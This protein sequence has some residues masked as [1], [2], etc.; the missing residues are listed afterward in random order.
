MAAS[1]AG[2]AAVAAGIASDCALLAAAGAGAT[3]KRSDGAVLC[4]SGV[5]D[6][7]D[8]GMNFSCESTGSSAAS[9][10]GRAVAGP[11]LA[12][13]ALGLGCC[14]LGNRDTS[15]SEVSGLATTPSCL[16]ACLA[17]KTD[18]DCGFC[19]D[20]KLPLA[21][22]IGRNGGIM[23]LTSAIC[24][25]STGNP[26]GNAVAACG[27]STDATLSLSGVASCAMEEVM[28]SAAGAS[29]A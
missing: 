12:S 26:V 1:V 27:T 6:T 24:A 14:G 29:L 7:S 25:G 8:T 13:A 5:P 18:A 20:A 2:V 23:G 21:F 17:L 10:G 28:C 4:C 19:D 15:S 11:A 9:A 3:R 22:G 16:I